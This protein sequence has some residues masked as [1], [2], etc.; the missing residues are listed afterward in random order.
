MKK[1][2][3]LVSSL[4]LAATVLVGN[5]LANRPTDFAH[6]TVQAAEIVSLKITQEKGIVKINQEMPLRSEPSRQGK[7]LRTLPANSRWRFF[8]YV[9][10]EGYWW[11][12]VGNNQWVVGDQVTS[13][14]NTTKTPST[15]PTVK[16]AQ[17]LHL[18]SAT[19]LYTALGATTPSATTLP[20]NS[21]WIYTQQQVV[22]QSTWYQVGKNQWV[23][24]P[25][26]KATVQTGVLKLTGKTTT[27][28]GP[29]FKYAQVGTLAASTNWKYTQ[30]VQADGY[31]WY[32]VGR[33]TWA[34]LNQVAVTTHQT[35]H[36][37]IT[38]TVPSYLRRGYG[39]KATLAQTTKLKAKTSWRYTKTATADGYT[40]YLIGKD[41][42]VA[43]VNA[44]LS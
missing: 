35:S 25:L 40:W 17:V 7:E 26:V 31:T 37:I 32:L 38:L 42:W 11:F 9:K 1:S 15:Q 4:A 39:L 34:G 14:T 24:V 6:Q 41:L 2:K 30:V 29:G 22:G 10:N 21:N 19:P 16:K 28:K 36:H 27:R 33:D 23:A 20:A 8:A 13:T 44:T 12:E 3:V 43:G 5:N 18:T